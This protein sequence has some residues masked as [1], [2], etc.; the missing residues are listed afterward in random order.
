MMS[1]FDTLNKIKALRSEAFAFANFHSNYQNKYA[2]DSRCDKKGYGFGKDSR[3]AAFRVS[4]EFS[5]WAGYYGNSS[6]SKILSVYHGAIVAP[7]ILEALDVHQKEIFAT[8]A[9][10][11]REEAARLTGNASKE[12]E[13]LQAMLDAAKADIVQ[14]Q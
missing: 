9:R 3:F 2:N 6:C 5:S 14:E 7:F 10:L 1:N 4:A 13:A 12:L 8:A 11:M